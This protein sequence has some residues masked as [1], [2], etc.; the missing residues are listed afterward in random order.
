M[1]L[2]LR[3]PRALSGFACGGLLALAGA[4][5]QVLLRNP[6]ADPYVLGISGGAAVGALSAMLAGLALALV[7]LAAFAG[8]LAAMLL[9][10]K[11]RSAHAHGGMFHEKSLQVSRE[12]W[13]RLWP[14]VLAN[15]I[16]G[17]TLGVTCMQWALATTNAA[18]VTAIIALTPVILLPMTRVIEGEK[19]GL[20]SLAGS[21]IAISGVIGLT[22][23]R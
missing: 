15:A 21:F 22:L 16:A 19:I 8:A 20:R 14:W 1:V 3:L 12:K 11:W 5:M 9:V 6:L 18:V 7:N 23:F 2:K 17:Q 13:T 10:F 4:L